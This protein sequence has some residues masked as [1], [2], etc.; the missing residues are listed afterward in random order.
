MAGLV[1]I[2][3]P[4]RWPAKYAA[5]VTP[6]SFDFTAWLAT[7]TGDT[8]TA[9]TAAA[10]GGGITVGVVS[11]VNA[12]VTVWLSGGAEGVDYVVV[13]TVTASSGRSENFPVQISVPI[14]A[15]VL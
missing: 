11:R 15:A 9:V 2:P 3:I 4:Y 8:I 12:L 10:L 1:N 13:V 7:I 5:D 14:I 6:R